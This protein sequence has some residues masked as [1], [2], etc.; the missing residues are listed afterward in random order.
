MFSASARPGIIYIP[1]AG[2]HKPRHHPATAKAA[3]TTVKDM[4]AITITVMR[5]GVTSPFAKKFERPVDEL[6]QVAKEVDIF[7]VID[8]ALA[9]IGLEAGAVWMIAG[10]AASF[11][12]PRLALGGGESAALTAIRTR[13]TKRGLAL[14]II[15]GADGRSDKWIAE[16]GFVKKN[17]DKL[18]GFEPY[19]KQMM[20]IYNTSFTAGLV[21]GRLFSTVALVHMLIFLGSKMTNY[22]R[23]EYLG[24]PKEMSGKE[25]E[26]YSR[27]WDAKK[28]I[29]YYNLL[30]GLLEE[31]VLKK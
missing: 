7:G 3:K 12:A 19:E 27:T 26:A 13:Y 15:L 1:P 4:S 23:A 29:N 5:D 18:L 6:E 10:F 14:G 20:N 8:F 28:W 30:A 17:P 25:W 24:Y 22:A 2:W 9:I 11:A 16:H 31:H 21:H